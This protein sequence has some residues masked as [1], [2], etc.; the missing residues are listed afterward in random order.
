M[1]PNTDVIKNGTANL[2]TGAANEKS[3]K[4]VFIN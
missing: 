1:T 3:R 2:W 4:K